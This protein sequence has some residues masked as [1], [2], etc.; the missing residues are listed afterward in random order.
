M[1]HTKRNSKVLLNK[2]K[3]NKVSE[4]N[5]FK[6]NPWV[7]FGKVYD[8]KTKKFYRL[9]STKSFNVIKNMTKNTEWYNRVTYM[10]RKNNNFGNKLKSLL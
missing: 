6:S 8:K 2:T 5:F 7:K 1:K 4:H 10:S 3:K 9:G